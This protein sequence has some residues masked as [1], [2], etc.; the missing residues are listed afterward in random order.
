MTLTIT[1][2]VVNGSNNTWGTLL[3]TALDTIVSHVNA[4]PAFPSGGIIMWSGAIANIPTGFVICDGTNGTPDLTDR[5]I[6]GSKTDSGATHDI[7]DTGGANSLTLSS[8]QLPSHSHGV[9]NLAA[10]AGGAH[11]HTGNTSTVGNHTHTGGGAINSPANAIM[12]AF[13]TSTFKGYGV[14]DSSNTNTGAAGSHSHTVTINSGGSHSHNIAG[15]TGALGSGDS[16]D[17]RPAYYA[18]AFIMKS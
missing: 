12:G 4:L 11:T 8:G 7:G 6:V 9:G 1:K 5:F 10:A 13:N 15:N 16:V 14:G 18:L 3:N 17:N 2:P